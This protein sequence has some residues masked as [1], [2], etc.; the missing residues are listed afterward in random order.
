MELPANTTFRR[1]ALATTSAVIGGAVWVAAPLLPAATGLAAG[2]VGHLFLLMPL[3]VS[4]L[5]LAFLAELR[6]DEGAPSAVLRLARSIQP[7]A[8][9]LLLLSFA[10]PTG[11]WAGMLSLPWLGV[12]LALAASG[13]WQA[14]RRWRVRLLTV[15]LVAAQ[16][17]LGMGAVWLL[18]WRLGVDPGNLSPLMVSLAAVHFHFNG[19]SA[20][21][22]IG[23]T[24]RRLAEASA[25]LRALHAVVSVAAVGGLP[26]LALGKAFAMPVAR[27]AGVG[28]MTL[29]MIGL[30]VTMYAV[31]MGVRSAATRALL[32]VSAGSGAA[33]VGLASAFGAAELAHREWISIGTMLASHG[34]LMGLGFTL[35]GIVGYR[36]RDAGAVSS[37][38]SEMVDW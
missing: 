25:R 5:A 2:S 10:L 12:A 13:V 32:L 22:L 27:I 36:Q 7:G 19:F 28:A 23:G 33:A 18:L 38:P 9:A 35:C 8:A 17:F 3:V 31:A 6:D 11:E 4:P 29:A 26:V 1:P 15:N 14:G 21:L 30:S 37:Q 20:Q 34:A 16:L 24:G